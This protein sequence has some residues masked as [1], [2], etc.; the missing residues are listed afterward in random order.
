MKNKDQTLDQIEKD[1]HAIQAGMKLEKPESFRL[2]VMTFFSAAGCFIAAFLHSAHSSENHLNASGRVDTERIIYLLILAGWILVCVTGIKSKA[3][4]SLTK[5]EFSLSLKSGLISIPAILLLKAWANYCGI[6]S[7]H[8]AS[9]LFISSSI[10]ITSI[11]L[12][13]YRRLSPRSRL[14]SIVSIPFLAAMGVLIGHPT[15][16]FSYVGFHATIGGYFLTLAIN[17]VLRTARSNSLGWSK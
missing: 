10:T 11:L 4:T 5:K 9:F 14:I 7:T 3:A 16:S 13:F 15:N 1:I 2:V 17:L 8:L 6:S 12:L